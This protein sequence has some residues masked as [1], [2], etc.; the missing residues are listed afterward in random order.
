MNFLRE[1]KK[2]FII[3]MAALCI[4]AI[5][6][7]ALWTAKPQAMQTAAGYVISPFQTGVTKVSNWFRSKVDY[8]AHMSSLQSEND[9]LIAENNTLKDE[10]TRLS[11]S[12]KDYAE[13]TQLYQLDQKY[14]D[15]PKTGA[16]II[17]QDPSDWVDQYTINKGT[18]S[19][20]AQYM[21]VLSGGGLFGAITDCGATTSTVVSI[22]DDRSSV[23]AMCAR[24]GDQGFV[25]GDRAL[26]SDGQCKMVYID[27]DAQIIVGDEIVTSSVSTVYPAGL[28]IGTVTAITDDPSGLTETAII[29]P[30]AA[31]DRPDKVLVVTKTN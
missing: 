3:I 19:G 15:Y 27:I 28:T 14:A 17:A 25:K 30:A 8:F 23:S 24:T 6:V 9:A 21:A 1:H 12:V 5:A 29:T 2:I 13:L 26:M 4:V 7:T 16:E 18:S 20:L 22:L 31:F 11:L 10:N